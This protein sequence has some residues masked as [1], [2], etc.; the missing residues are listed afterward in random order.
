MQDNN[1]ETEVIPQK[2][3]ISDNLFVF[4]VCS[5]LALVL[6]GWKPF[7]VG[8]GIM[9]IQTLAKLLGSA[10]ALF[11][12]GWLA[13][14]LLSTLLKTVSLKSLWLATSVLFFVIS[15]IGQANGQ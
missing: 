5:I 4:I 13:A 2:K 12:M 8:L 15:L 7:F 11:I 3:G 1:T 10:G 9:P 14:K 6:M